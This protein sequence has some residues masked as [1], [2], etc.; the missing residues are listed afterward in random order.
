MGPGISLREAAG[1]HPLQAPLGAE[2]G[3]VGREV[4][5]GRDWVRDW[6]WAQLGPSLPAWLSP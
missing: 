3:L 6:V 2:Q 1:K 5:W 4:L